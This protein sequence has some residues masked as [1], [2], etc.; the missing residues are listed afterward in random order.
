MEEAGEIGTEEASQGKG[1]GNRL[2]RDFTE[3]FSELFF[4]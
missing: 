1:T 4:Q 3:S 2:S